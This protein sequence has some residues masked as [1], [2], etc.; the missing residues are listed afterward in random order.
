MARVTI[1]DL[2]DRLGLSKFSVSRALSGK[3]GVSEATRSRVLRAAHAMG[4]RLNSEVTPPTGQILFIRQEIDPVS[5]ER[6]LN[7]M[8]GAER[9]GERLGFA[10]LPRQARYLADN[11]HLDP[12]IVGIILAVARPGEVADLAL[13]TGLPVASANYVRPFDPIDQVVGADWETGLRVA[14]FLLGLG[15]RDFAFVRGNAWPVARG[16]RFRGFRDGL[17]QA[18]LGECDDLPFDEAV[19]FRP[20]LLDYLGR[21]RGPTALFCAHDG[22]AVTVISELLRLGVRVPEDVSVVGVND[23]A[24]ASQVAPRLTTMRQPMVETGAALVRCIA[25][26]LARADGATTPPRRIALLAELIER[27]STGPASG[28]AWAERISSREL[29]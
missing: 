17:A 8:H 4:Y 6:W 13:R 27:E 22:I 21:G 5:A 18:G 14:Q 19:G 11:S 3:A 25:D 29:A 24:V 16:E 7:I 26:R 10:V 1:Q 20:A 23:L 28:R 2:A 9:E 15:H 12:G